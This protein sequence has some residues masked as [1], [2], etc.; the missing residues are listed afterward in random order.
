MKQTERTNLLDKL[1][2]YYGI[3]HTSRII[4]ILDEVDEK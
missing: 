3:E 1:A 4:D 2:D